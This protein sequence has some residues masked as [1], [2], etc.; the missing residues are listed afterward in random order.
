MTLTT[1]TRSLRYRFASGQPS[2]AASGGVVFG[3]AH[4][5]VGVAAGHCS[6]EH[7]GWS[8]QARAC[9]ACWERAIRDDER[10]VVEWDLPRE[11]SPD[12]LFVDEIAVQLACQGTP[13][14]L[15]PVEVTAAVMRLHGRGLSAGE[16]G[17]RL[18]RDETVIRRRL[19]DATGSAAPLGGEAA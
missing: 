11:Q 1:Y 2:A 4:P 7:P 3:R 17:H 8:R 19:L 18:G 12:P 9:A 6:P 5:L 15:T 13:V 14:A 16:I 10:F